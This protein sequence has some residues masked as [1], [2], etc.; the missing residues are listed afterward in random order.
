[1]LYCS[2]G[3]AQD[4]GVVNERR[5]HDGSNSHVHRAERQQDELVRASLHL[6]I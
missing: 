5:R 3:V 4:A 6:L 1:M 2:D